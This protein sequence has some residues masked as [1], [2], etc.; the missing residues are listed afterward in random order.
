MLVTAAAE[1]VRAMGSLLV[2]ADAELALGATRNAAAGVA[3]RRARELED[4]RT[5]HDL[6][7]L[8]ALPADAAPAAVR[9]V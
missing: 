3:M 1:V 5:L 6:H 4:A 7:R 8:E 2:R 9:G